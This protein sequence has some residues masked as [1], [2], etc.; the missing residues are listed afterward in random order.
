MKNYPLK[1]FL[2]CCY[3][4]N[5]RQR[6]ELHSH[7]NAYQLFYCLS[8]E[9]TRT[10]GNRRIA[11]SKGQAILASPGMSHGM[12]Y[13]NGNILDIKFAV[14]D[15]TLAEKL[16]QISG[17][18]IDCPEAVSLFLQIAELTENPTAYSSRL[19]ELHLE[20]AFYTI[21]EHRHELGNSEPTLE[22]DVHDFLND[23]RVGGHIEQWIFPFIDGYIIL[24]AE[25]FSVSKLA[26]EI[27]YNSQYLG[28]SFSNE[29]GISL[30]KYY[31]N[32]R[33]SIAKHFLDTTDLTVSEI[34]DILG[35][36]D[37]QYFV[38]HF[39]KS[40]GLLPKTYRAQ[41]RSAKKKGSD[42]NPKE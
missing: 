4:F 3:S 33:I 19:K 16:N 40:T 8:G 5:G 17:C 34:A 30:T 7:K 32:R 36:D 41:G 21:F 35:F 38:K 10:C 39:K 42:H 28:R 24:P 2:A 27:G 14:F 6:T 12:T 37:V 29:M 11:L 25:K 9:T 23:S 22:F 1:I 18:R 20:T 13:C 15:D 31:Y 26:R